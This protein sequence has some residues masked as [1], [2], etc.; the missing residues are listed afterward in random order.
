M[1]FGVTSRAPKATIGTSR[2]LQ[3]RQPQRRYTP[4]IAVAIHTARVS[5]KITPN[6]IT[7]AQEPQTHKCLRAEGE[8]STKEPSIK[9]EIISKT[10]K[11]YQWLMKPVMRA[12]R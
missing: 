7:N 11:V 2:T 1:V 3:R 10:E 12:E 9:S 5:A 6:P 8:N 4:P